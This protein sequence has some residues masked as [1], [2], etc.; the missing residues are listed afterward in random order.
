M[1]NNVLLTC[2]QLQIGYRGRAL[3]P[4]IDMAVQRGEIWA[5]IGPNG[6]G[7]TTLLRTL[8]GLLPAVGGELDRTGGAIGYVPQ[9]TDLDPS[10]PAR[11][12]DLVRAGTERR[13]SFLMP[14]LPWSRPPAVLRALADVGAE[15]LAM[16]PWQHLSEGQKQRVLM[17]QALAGAPDLLILDEPTSAMDLHAERSVFDLLA[18]LRDK[19]NL[20]LLLVSHNLAMLARYATHALFVDKD[21]G[22]VLAGT[23]AEVLAQRAFEARFGVH[24]PGGGAHGT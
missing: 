15:H 12:I 7:K 22:V 9:R 24:L 11:A 3:L 10:V 14:S 13:W 1:G 21:Q 17:A 18:A 20:G 16:E 6:S 19:R 4:S 2:R 8:L 5:L 23:L